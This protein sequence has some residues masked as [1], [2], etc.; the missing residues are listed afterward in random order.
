MKLL[1]FIWN[2]KSQARHLTANMFGVPLLECPRSRRPSAP[3][4]LRWQGYIQTAPCTGVSLV[5]WR[6]KGSWVKSSRCLARRLPVCGAKSACAAAT[7]R[8]HWSQTAMTA[9][10]PGK[11]QIQEVGESSHWHTQLNKQ[12][13]LFFTVTEVMCCQVHEWSKWSKMRG[14]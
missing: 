3:A 14:K 2:A 12:S 6:V 13:S 4:H 7:S 1:V 11:W 5:L 10:K 9:Q 8:I